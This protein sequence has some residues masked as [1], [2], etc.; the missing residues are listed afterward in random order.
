MVQGQGH[1]SARASDAG[2]L[3]AF[4]RL[5]GVALDTNITSTVDALL[6]AA[7]G[8]TANI[9]GAEGLVYTFYPQ[10]NMFEPLV[11]YR[12]GDTISIEDP[13]VISGTRR[14]AQIEV[15]INGEYTVYF[16]AVRLVGQTAVNEAVDFLLR[17]FQQADEVFDPGDAQIFG[18]GGMMTVAVAASNASASSQSKADFICDG[19][20]DQVLINEAIQI[21]ADTQGG[22][23]WLSEGAFNI[24][25]LIDVSG[26]AI[27]LRGLG[28]D[29]ILIFSQDFDP[30]INLGPQSRL[31][32]MTV[33][34]IIS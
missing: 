31:L 6:A 23:V 12:P 1:L 24:D 21:C 30:L 8:V 16:S 25:G 19:T 4:G 7:N 2:L 15:A 26:Q 11:A 9:A 14:I 34:G 10:A 32:D 5:E 17:K 33:R 27:D 18:G 22:T 29:T 20:D 3:A 13:P 28:Y